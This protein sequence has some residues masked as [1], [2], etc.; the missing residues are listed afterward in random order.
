MRYEKIMCDISLIQPKEIAVR[1]HDINVC[2]ERNSVPEFDLLTT[3]GMAVR[4][5]LHLRG[6]QAV[7]YHLIRNVATYLLDFPAPAVKP[8]LF[9]LAEAEFIKL[10]TE[11]NTIKTIIPNVPYYEKLFIDL[12]EVAGRDNFSE[13]EQLAIILLHKLADSPL[14]KE[15][16]YQ[17]GAEKNHVN[18]IIDIGTQGSFLLS[19][20]VRGRNI[21]LSPTYFSE[22]RDA[23]ADLVAAHGAGRVKKALKLLKANQGWPLAKIQANQGIGRYKLDE[24]DIAVILKLAG[25]GFVGSVKFF[26]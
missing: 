6:I 26:V 10:V 3:L 22:S 23:Y 21:L 20:R 15:H 11:G 18:R 9:F 7:S 16:I 13:H 25:E 14:L 12:G 1:A 19:K 4:L 5:A 17:F 2:L 8:V 24:A